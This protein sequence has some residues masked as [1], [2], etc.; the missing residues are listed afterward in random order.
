MLLS[1]L[2]FP[3][4]KAN[5]QQ[6]C[7]R[8]PRTTPARALT[9][10]PMEATTRTRRSPMGTVLGPGVPSLRFPST[11]PKYLRHPRDKVRLISGSISLLCL[12]PWRRFGSL[13]WSAQ[14][15]MDAKLLWLVS[16]DSGRQYCEVCPTA[17]RLA[18]RSLSYCLIVL[19]LIFFTAG[20]SMPG[21]DEDISPYATF[22]LLGMREEVTLIIDQYRHTNKVVR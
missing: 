12:V 18:R 3:T 17:V 1:F 21:Q 13:R 9:W 16:L 6:R 19:R 11:M 15:P 4:P 20:G 14:S 2:F 8:M 22:H 10:L 7:E 5:R